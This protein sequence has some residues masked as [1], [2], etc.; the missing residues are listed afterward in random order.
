MYRSETFLNFYRGGL[1][2]LTTKLYSL[3]EDYFQRISKDKNQLLLK[4]IA[5]L[6]EVNWPHT[7]IGKYILLVYT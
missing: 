1:E 4:I 3:K 6:L 2:C 7:W 5:G